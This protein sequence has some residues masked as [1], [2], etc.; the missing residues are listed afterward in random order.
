MEEAFSAILED[1]WSLP[2]VI[3]RRYGGDSSTVREQLRGV[4]Q[5]QGADRSFAGVLEDGSVVTWGD[6]DEGGGSS[7]IRVYCGLNLLH[8]LELISKCRFS[9]F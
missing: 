4:E 1:G 8:T 7:R 5:I 6:P 2:G 9:T 3:Y